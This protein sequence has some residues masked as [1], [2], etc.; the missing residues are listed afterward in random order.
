MSP[1]AD[2]EGYVSK[3]YIGEYL[4]GEF[5]YRS[6]YPTF[7]LENDNDIWLANVVGDKDYAAVPMTESRYF[8]TTLTI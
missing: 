4:S 5:K 6:E 1:I 2:G 7:F 3:V 8:S